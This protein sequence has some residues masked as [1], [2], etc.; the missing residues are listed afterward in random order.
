MKNDGMQKQQS[1]SR[2]ATAMFFL[3][4]RSEVI[5]YPLQINFIRSN[6]NSRRWPLC[7]VIITVDQ[8]E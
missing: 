1:G 8:T 6:E 7:Q 2:I 3:D 5:A 4:K